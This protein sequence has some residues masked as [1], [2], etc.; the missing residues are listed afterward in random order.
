MHSPP[1]Y[2]NVTRLTDLLGLES[3][4]KRRSTGCSTFSCIP[5]MGAPGNISWTLIPIGG[6]VN[7]S[8]A[9]H[10]EVKAKTLP[11]YLHSKKVQALTPRSKVVG[12]FRSV[13]CSVF[14]V[15]ESI[16]DIRLILFCN[17][18]SIIRDMEY[19]FSM[20]LFED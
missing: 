5:H 17:A 16:E 11:I 14:R 15:E 12:L 4:G 3:D 7:T 10:G 18:H 13:Q 20:L 9:C 2:S 19:Y 8:L 1:F 6:D